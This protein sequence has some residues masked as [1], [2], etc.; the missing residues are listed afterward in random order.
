MPAL[1]RERGKVTGVGR[2]GGARG[3]M[4]GEHSPTPAVTGPIVKP[5]MKIIPAGRG[6]NYTQ[7]HS[8]TLGLQV[9]MFVSKHTHTLCELTIIVK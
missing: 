8:A 2:G 3:L 7:L 4:G 5:V 6:T 9:P 1:K